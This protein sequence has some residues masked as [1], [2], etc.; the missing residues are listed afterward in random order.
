MQKI[1]VDTTKRKGAIMRTREEGLEPSLKVLETFVLP[2]KLFSLLVTLFKVYF[3]VET[4]MF[5]QPY[6]FNKLINSTS[7]VARSLW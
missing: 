2:I 6:P 7:N 3:V 1:F 5:P 4:L